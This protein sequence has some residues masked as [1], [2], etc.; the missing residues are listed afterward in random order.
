MMLQNRDNWLFITLGSQ[1]AN[2]TEF[3]DAWRLKQEERDG[4]I[5][6]VVA[7]A[8]RFTVGQRNWQAEEQLVRDRLAEDEPPL[9]R[10]HLEII[11]LQGKDGQFLED[12]RTEEDANGGKTTI[13]STV[14]KLDK[15]RK[16]RGPNFPRFLFCLA[17]GRKTMSSDLMLAAMLTQQDDDRV[18]HLF[19]YP[20][21]NNACYHL[22]PAP[23][24]SQAKDAKKPAAEF[25]LVKY[26]APSLSGLYSKLVDAHV[27]QPA[28]LDRFNEIIASVTKA[29]AT[30][31][32][33]AFTLVGDIQDAGL[34]SLLIQLIVEWSSPSGQ[35]RLWGNDIY[36][37]FVDHGFQHVCS[38]LGHASRICSLIDPP[39]S[40]VEL[41]ALVAAIWLHDI[42]MSGDGGTT[43]RLKVRE[44]HGELSEKRI[45]H[46]MA[47]WEGP[48]QNDLFKKLAPVI[49]TIVSYHQKHRPLDEEQAKSGGKGPPPIPKQV[50]NPLM[51]EAPGASSAP[52]IRTRL[53]AAILQLCDACDVQE[54]RL[55]LSPDE[56]DRRTRQ[57]MKQLFAA[58]LDRLDL[59]RLQKSG[60]D[61]A[62]LADE[63]AEAINGPPPSQKPSEDE[64]L[65]KCLSALDLVDDERFRS[66]PPD[67]RLLELAKELRLMGEQYQNHYLLHHQ[68]AQVTIDPPA[69]LVQP[70]QLQTGPGLRQAQYLR[71]IR[72]NITDD[73]DLTFTILAASH[74]EIDHVR[75]EGMEPREQ[76]IKFAIPS[77]HVPDVL[78]FFQPNPVW[79]ELGGC[80]AQWNKKTAQMVTDIYFDTP[81]RALANG[82]AGIRLREE[83]IR[84]RTRRFLCYK[85][86]AAG[87]G[88]VADRA[89][90][91]ILVTA[92]AWHEPRKAF[93]R[94]YERLSQAK[95]RLPDPRDLKEAL[96]LRNHRIFLPLVHVDA[97]LFQSKCGLYLDEVE[98][99]HDDRQE[100]FYE[101]EIEN[102]FGTPDLL[103]TLRQELQQ[104]L[105]FL[106][107]ESRNKYQKSLSLIMPSS[108]SS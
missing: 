51:G 60:Q 41:F 104:H 4:A 34:R 69:I 22:H 89:E 68:S 83:V 82:G 102:F 76:E 61:G 67:Q 10:D 73:L 16:N 13:L 14:Q 94:L 74:V 62:R 91:E 25:Y 93:E 65:R 20:E 58:F 7:F 84:G 108:T 9:A 53:L 19:V 44:C 57:E 21:N 6:R 66:P 72:Q 81:D 42:G 55:L 80:R 38:V 8:T 85:G 11:Y 101:L 50:D 100:K 77:Q 87:G 96:T 23:E 90:W 75:I 48:P 28:D 105:S 37:Y 54:K 46:E 33:Q 1:F 5:T 26:P 59:V 88:A 36:R 27:F 2:L 32:A 49:G 15:E 107:P 39:L 103:E 63:L 92:E 52:A 3:L 79:K 12:I 45:I 97:E 47:R 17:G 98:V 70:G 30:N 56:K 35:E 24:P 43:E 18:Y 31:T 86:P 106:E 99:V 95:E 78:A 40:D 64:K 71:Q 29:M